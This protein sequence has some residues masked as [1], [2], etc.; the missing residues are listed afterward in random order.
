[1]GFTVYGGNEDFG[2]IKHNLLGVQYLGQAVLHHLCIWHA[3]H[4][5]RGSHNTLTIRTLSVQ[6]TIPLDIIILT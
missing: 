6:N 3:P 2:E 4:L 5:P 1:M